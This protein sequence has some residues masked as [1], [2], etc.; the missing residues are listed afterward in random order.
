MNFKKC[1]HG[2][3]YP[4]SRSE[5]PHCNDISIKPKPE[6][7][8]TSNDDNKT[9]IIVGQPKEGNDETKIIKKDGG[10]TTS[11]RTVIYREGENP[12]ESPK[13]GSTRKL[14]GWLVSYTLDENG[15]DFKLFEGKNNLGRGTNNDI[16]I[17]NDSQLSSH[18][19]TILFRSGSFFVKDEMSANP[20]FL[21]G[22]EIP[23]ASAKQLNDGDKLKFGNNE[24]IFRKALKDE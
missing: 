9:T 20:S 15:I 11:D 16:K 23:P 4:A 3:F 22:E 12:K 18:H 21:N 24:Y 10:N 8:H 17:F 5:C 1:K 19:A 6:S 14:V 7:M 2:H 13:Q